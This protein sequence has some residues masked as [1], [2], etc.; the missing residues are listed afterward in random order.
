MNDPKLLHGKDLTEHLKVTAEK[1]EKEKRTE[2]CR[3]EVNTVLEKHNCQLDAIMIIGRNGALPQ[4]SI[5][6]NNA[7]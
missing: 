6:A 7:K 5:V 4:I 2:E 1:E 3:L